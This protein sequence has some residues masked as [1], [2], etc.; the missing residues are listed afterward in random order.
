A[1]RARSPGARCPPLRSHT[2]GRRGRRRGAA[3]APNRRPRRATGRAWRLAPAG[4]HLEPRIVAKLW[5]SGQRA[6]LLELPALLGPA[7][8]A[9]APAD[10]EQRGD[11]CI[12]GP[13]AE[14]GAEVCSRPGVEA[15]EPGAVGGDA[16]PVAGA[17]EGRRRR[18]DDAEGRSVRK[19][20][21]LGRIG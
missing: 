7:A 5:R 6:T 10:P 12:A 11:L 15:G 16:A 18:G 17:A 19:A 20:E 1:P 14:R 2:P 9:R 8:G 13:V 21:A 4:V 3:P